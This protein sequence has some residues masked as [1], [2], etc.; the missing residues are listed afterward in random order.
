MAMEKNVVKAGITQRARSLYR[1]QD[2][3]QRGR[4]QRRLPDRR[5]PLRPWDRLETRPHRRALRHRM[6]TRKASTVDATRPSTE[7]TSGTKKWESKPAQTASTTTPI[8]PTTSIAQVMTDDRGRL[9]TSSASLG[10]GPSR[11]LGTRKPG[12]RSISK[13]HHD[14]SQDHDRG[15]DHKHQTPDANPAPRASATH[16]DRERHDH[17]DSRHDEYN[18]CKLDEH[19]RLGRRRERCLPR[20]AR[21]SAKSR[22]ARITRIPARPPRL[23]SHR[24]HVRLAG[25]PTSVF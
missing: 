22:R 16:R 23:R 20:R 24:P 11:P 7:R 4:T 5:P 17:R 14:C 12:D 6:S 9:M 2:G 3:L 10:H 25:G 13:E 18:F 15:R 21:R 19:Q 8:E 1:P